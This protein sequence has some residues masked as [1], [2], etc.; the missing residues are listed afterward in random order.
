MI[1]SIIPRKVFC[2]VSFVYLFR[3][4]MIFGYRW[5]ILL[6][7]S[8]DILLIVYANLR[9]IPFIAFIVICCTLQSIVLGGHCKALHANLAASI[10]ALK[11][12]VRKSRMQKYSLS[13][14]LECKAMSF[15]LQ[16]NILV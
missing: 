13:A 9:L 12:K 5:Y 6:A 14:E 4:K 3:E 10:V 1:F 7:A 11:R 16:H 8:L 15:L 2:M